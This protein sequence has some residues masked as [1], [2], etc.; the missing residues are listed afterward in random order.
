MGS[1]KDVALANEKILDQL[2]AGQDRLAE[3]LETEFEYDEEQLDGRVVDT[4]IRNILE[5]KAAE[6]NHV[7]D[8]RLLENER[9]DH[10]VTRRVVWRL[11][12]ELDRLDCHDDVPEKTMVDRDMTRR[13]VSRVLNDEVMRA[14]EA[15]GQALADE[16]VLTQ[17]LMNGLLSIQDDA[18]SVMHG[19]FTDIQH[20]NLAKERPTKDML[21]QAVLDRVLELTGGNRSLSR[22]PHVGSTVM[23]LEEDGERRFVVCQYLGVAIRPDGD[24]NLPQA[25]DLSRFHQLIEVLAHQGLVIGWLTDVTFL[26]VKEDEDGRRGILMAYLFLTVPQEELN[27]RVGCKLSFEEGGMPGDVWPTWKSEGDPSP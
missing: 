15:L 16:K 13:I 17:K 4:A 20:P 5:L 24:G 11:L 1:D 27:E 8:Q 21:A 9:S 7:D 14:N 3:F 26:E 10:F 2:Q 25:D 6:K 23:E 12:D 18:A 22:F 19:P